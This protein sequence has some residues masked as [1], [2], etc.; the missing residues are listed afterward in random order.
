MITRNLIRT[1]LALAALCAALP[2][3]ADSQFRIRRMTRNDVPPG[4]GQCDIV[5]QVDGDAE[6]SVRGDML[7]IHTI[8]GREPRDD[9]SECNAPLPDR[10]VPGFNY[11]QVESRDQMRMLAPPD[12]RNGFAVIVRIHDGP[13]GEGRYH[14]RLTWQITGGEDFGRG[15]RGGPPER[16]EPGF[17]PEDRRGG[18]EPSF[19]PDGRRGG[20][21]F[22]WN[23]TLRFSGAGRGTADL[24]PNAPQRLSDINVDI[25][26]A[27]RIVV[28][29]RAGFD[30]PLTL[31]GTLT[32]REG[33][34]YKADA[35][36]EDRRVRGPLYITISPRNEID[37][38]TFEA[39]DR[40]RRVRVNWQRR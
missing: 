28:S 7:L 22:G 38:L 4:R 32:G 1:G 35:M 11:Q 6:V 31:T 13:G 30:R 15:N 17:P 24:P 9:G 19:P 20:S 25:D 29:F 26:R 12:R 3:L 2:A 5:L 10:D 40:G 37:A 23:N 18:P 16:P 27:G 14:F 39:T 21:G 36:T 8:G 34:Q 33:L